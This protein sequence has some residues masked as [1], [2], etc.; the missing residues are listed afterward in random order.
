MNK[1]KIKDNVLT[2]NTAQS[3]YNH[4]QTLL[5][6]P[7]SIYRWVW[8]LLQNARDASEGP[9]TLTASINYRSKE[10]VFLH[11]GRGFKEK[12]IG[13]L[14]F[15]GSTKTEDE[16]KIGQ[17]GSGFLTT[18]LLSWAINVSGQLDEDE[19]DGQ[20][21]D[22]CLERK[23]D[24]EVAL[25]ESMDEAWENFNPSSSPIQDDDFA[26]GDG[27]TT[28]FAYP[29]DTEEARK[30]V[31][32]GIAMLRE[33]APFVVVFNPEFSGININID[34]TD[35]SEELCF[36]VLERSPLET[37]GIEQITVAESNSEIKKYL[38][39]EGDK[40]SV[41]VLNSDNSECLP[42][43]A[44]PRLFLGF[45]LVGTKSFSFP[46]VINSF[47]F[48]A[49]PDREGVWLA[50]DG[51]AATIEN[52]NIIEEACEL[53]V[54][55]V[56]YAASKKWEHVHKWVKIP[57]IEN[58]KW[59]DANWLRDC[60][61]DS[62]IEKMRQTPMVL[63]TDGNPINPEKVK[64]PFAGGQ[65]GIEALWDLFEDIRGQRELLPKRK[66]A[67]GWCDAIESWA[68]V[69]QDEPISFRE[70][71]DGPELASF[72]EG[73]THQGNTCGRIE[74]LQDLLREEIAAVEWLNRLHGFFNENELDEVVLDYHIVIDQAGFLNTLPVLHRDAGIDDNLKD[75]AELLEWRIRLNLRD[76]RLTSL[77]EKEGAGDMN[78]NE[79]VDTLCQKLRDRADEN[80]DEDFQEA[81]ARLF[82]WIVGQEDWN[83]LRGFP[84]FAKDSKSDSPILDLPTAHSGELPLAPV[85]AWDE[86]LQQ[87]S[88]LFPPDRILADVFFKKVSSPETWKQLDEQGFI[89]WDM[90]I[91]RAMTD[92]KLLSPEVSEDKQDHKTAE[93]II[94]VTDFV[95]RVAIMDW[96]RNTRE[97][98]YLF[99]RFLTEWLIKA[100]SQYLEVRTAKCNSCEDDISHEYHMAAWLEP[101]RNNLW[102]HN[103]KDKQRFKPNARELARLLRNYGWKL[104][105]LDENPDAAKL[106]EA[107]GV[108]P[109]DLRLEFMADDEEKRDILINTA[110][111]LYDRPQLVHYM[112]TN[113]NLPDNLERI[114]EV[115]GGDLS[116]VV[117]DAEKRQ[118]QQRT[119]DENR[120]LGKKVGK[121][122]GESLDKK[123]FNVTPVDI[124][125]DFEIDLT[126]LD[127][128]QDKQ[129]WWIE[130]KSARTESVK[131]SSKQ[132]QNALDKGEN[133]LLCVVPISENGPLNPEVVKSNMR[134]IKNIREKLGDRVAQLCESIEDQEI[135][136]T[137]LPDD[138]SSGV[139]L[140]FEAGK[141]EIHV[142][143]SVW[144]NEGFPLA[145]LAEHLK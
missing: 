50:K 133:F 19:P 13:H 101:V 61:R 105:S 26:T 120:D 18:H 99:W 62:L 129:E 83:N 79:V 110:T 1:V 7:D 23:P 66:E 4:L 40:A 139:D 30:A 10:L 137:E 58:Q 34:T 143:N 126:T 37:S 24:S 20:W 60:I 14:I 84:V 140:D 144:E 55:L 41:T 128:T 9:N 6:T 116:Q 2:E 77:S 145:K 82:A 43:E 33:C 45:P 118:K 142:K 123:G 134:F 107:I 86:D 25:R 109:S 49:T 46:A 125:A 67:T 138:T 76:I 38:L 29:I 102:I 131:M 28:R 78:S 130:V 27:F 15:H 111:T 53:L 85:G 35:C 54:D 108:T 94:G 36:K 72:I 113:E 63:N 100:D 52:R 80:P 3:V 115:T 70:V 121:W 21:F 88:E 22:F 119:V 44:I 56:G 95:E 32:E 89:R 65:I 127:V 135:V 90:I 69:Y 117:E 136:H 132:T 59:L 75:I 71:S 112:Q 11:N 124:G 96:V 16:G 47:K 64:L 104:N 51:D 141:A 39:A 57:P 81:S 98:A 106:L 114:V 68:D 91:Q 74:N 122:V 8:E 97:R 103:D 73:H 87:F 12:E 31:V 42:V 17:Y 48:S 5:K 93:P 92:L